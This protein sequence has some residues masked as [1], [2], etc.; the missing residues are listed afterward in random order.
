MV[1]AGVLPLAPVKA[2]HCQ[3]AL[4]L[5][6]TAFCVGSVYLKSCLRKVDSANGQV[7]HPII[8]AFL[9]EVTA[10]PI[11]CAM[12]WFSTGG[13]FQKSHSILSPTRLLATISTWS[14]VLSIALQGTLKGCKQGRFDRRTRKRVM[15]AY[16]YGLK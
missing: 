8:Y 2:W 1:A 14:P 6:Q 4:A 9:R 5:T 13:S 16:M 15:D 7:F 11:M 10:G 12:A 3:L